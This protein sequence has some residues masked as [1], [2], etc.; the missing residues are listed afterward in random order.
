MPLLLP[1]LYIIGPKGALTQRSDWLLIGS[2][3]VL[4]AAAKIALAVLTLLGASEYLKF[5]IVIG[6]FVAIL[7]GS[8]F[9]VLMPTPNR[10]R[11]ER[12]SE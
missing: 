4:G 11:K 10:L 3:V 2:L 9:Y 6:W 1:A 8:Y 5:A 7:V 12:D